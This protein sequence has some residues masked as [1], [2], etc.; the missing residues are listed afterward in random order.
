MS[1]RLRKKGFTLIE[2]MMGIAFMGIVLLGL[3]QLF[4]LSVMN[5]QRS[6]NV[7][8]ASFLAQQEIDLMRNCTA[9]ELRTAASNPIDDQVDINS[10]GTI[11]FRRITQVKSKGFNWSVE[12]LVFSPAQLSADVN[13]LI[14]NPGPNKVK[15]QIAT[16]ISR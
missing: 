13:E 2:A 12:I 7:T 10:D 9:D 1:R 6:G 8:S 5:N 3:A 4:C 14:A 11:D 15:S 16:I